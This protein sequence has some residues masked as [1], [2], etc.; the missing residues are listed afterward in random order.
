[1]TLIVTVSVNPIGYWLTRPTSHG[2]VTWMMNAS[3]IDLGCAATDAMLETLERNL[4]I[5]TSMTVNILIC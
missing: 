5:S 4:Q 2:N 1:V 3:A